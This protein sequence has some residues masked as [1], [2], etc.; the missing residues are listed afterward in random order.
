[1]LCRCSRDLRT[2]PGVDG[3]AEVDPRDHLERQVI[4]DPQQLHHL[5]H[6][7]EVRLRHL[8][9]LGD[10]G[11]LVGQLVRQLPGPVMDLGIVIRLGA[12]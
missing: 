9:V 4:D 6:V 8:P 7:H 1:M 2:R 5:A 11:K 10:E 12:P 3:V